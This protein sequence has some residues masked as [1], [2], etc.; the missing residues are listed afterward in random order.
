[1]CYSWK[2]GC[3]PCKLPVGT[4]IWVAKILDFRFTRRW[5]PRRR[6]RPPAVRHRVG[7]PT[8]AAAKAASGS[9]EDQERQERSQNAGHPRPRPQGLRPE[10]K[11][12]AEKKRKQEEQQIIGK[13]KADP[14]A[15]RRLARLCENAKRELSTAEDAEVEA[16][17]LQP[18][19]DLKVRVTRQAFEGL[20]ADLFESCLNTV[21]SVV[22]DAGC[23]M[24]DITECVVG[25]GSTRVPKLQ[26]KLY[27]QFGGRLE[28]VQ[29]GA[30]RR[31]RGGWCR[32]ARRHPASW[33]DREAGK[34]S[35][36]KAART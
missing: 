23:Q 18:G 4:R 8:R 36:R 27:A 32:G 16:E 13:L 1:M 25:G 31:G 33:F 3:L 11:R 24:S 17:E 19:L 21:E 10:K 14:K 34:T 28:L 12:A 29:D 20:C 15:M 35:R 9:R 2:V 26:E 22:R 6:R 7:V 5:S 30:P